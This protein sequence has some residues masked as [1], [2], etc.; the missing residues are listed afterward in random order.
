MAEQY[1]KQKKYSRI[2]GMSHTPYDR[3]APKEYCKPE[4]AHDLAEPDGH[5]NLSG[6]NV[7]PVLYPYE[8]SD[9]QVKRKKL[10]IPP[11]RL[12]FCGGGVRCVAHVGVL[13]A[14][15]ANGLLRC[16]K[17]V[18]GI[19]AGAFFALL[20]VLEYTVEQ[21]ELLA[22]E[23]DFTNLGTI[24]P[25]DILLFPLTFG[26]NSGEAIGR[27]ITSVLKQKGFSP[28]VTLAELSKGR[29]KFR[30]YATELQTTSIKEMSAKATPDMKVVA[31]VRASMSFPLMFSPVKDGNSLL[32]DGGLL[33]N[34][35]LVFLK[36][37]EIQETLCV[38]FAVKPRLVIEPVEEVLDFVKYMYEAAIDMRNRPYLKKYR[39]RLIIVNTDECN[40]LNFS[41]S[42][43]NRVSLIELA[44]KTT[45][46]FLFH[47]RTPRRR[48]S[49][50]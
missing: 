13:K 20:Y 16:V 46:D 47:N 3:S 41:E 5:I 35:P 27:L 17:E 2:V 38:F 25:E 14:L 18:T 19:S 44:Y 8:T 33:H 28:D 6:P 31:A 36:E 39:D 50:S 30:C 22:T 43:D 34:M 48:F 23:M 26:L 12:A 37:Q 40:G 1:I 7:E 15:K 29:I 11:R 21:M 24:D 49:V 10:C 4:G 45:E 42:R 9:K 32:V